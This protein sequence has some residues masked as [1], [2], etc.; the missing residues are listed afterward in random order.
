MVLF[1]I[2]KNKMSSLTQHE[3]AGNKWLSSHTRHG[4]QKVNFDN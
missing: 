4:V 1:K 3:I 2:L